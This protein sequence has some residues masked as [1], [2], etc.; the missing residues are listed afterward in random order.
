MEIVSGSRRA[1][2]HRSIAQKLAGW[3]PHNMQTCALM[4]THAHHI[5]AHVN[6]PYMWRHVHA[7]MR[8]CVLTPTTEY[9]L[10]HVLDLPCTETIMSLPGMSWTCPLSCT[11]GEASAHEFHV[12]SVR[13]ASHHATLTDVPS[14]TLNLWSR[15]E[16]A[17]TF[18]KGPDRKYFRLC[19]SYGLCC[20]ST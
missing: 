15:T 6:T 5:C 11:I 3:T 16:S 19:R 9:F 17:I 13:Q 8:P 12:A 1:I 2:T 10:W 7:H 20:K 18:Y 14:L 4:H